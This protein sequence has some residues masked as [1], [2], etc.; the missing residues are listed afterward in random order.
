[1][2]FPSIQKC[3]KL[4]ASRYNITTCELIQMVSCHVRYYTYL[5]RGFWRI[6]SFSCVYRR[7]N[8]APFEYKSLPSSPSPLSC[9]IQ[10][11]CTVFLL[12]YYICLS[13][14]LSM[15]VSSPDGDLDCPQFHIPSCTALQESALGNPWTCHVCM[16]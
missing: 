6:W 12:A 7:H 16:C 13:V 5:K 15:C 10:L 3:S 8:Y 9:G 14:C 1:M 2:F 4:V 11:Q